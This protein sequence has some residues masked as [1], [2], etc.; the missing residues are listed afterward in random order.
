MKKILA[1]VLLPLLLAGMFACTD[2]QGDG[3]YTLIWE[4]S[5]VPQDSSFRNPVW[6]PDLSYPSVFKAAVSYYAIGS[7][8]EWS[9][10]LNLKAP[11]LSSTDLMS[12]DRRGEALAEEPDWSVNSI[13]A[14][15]AG[16]AKT[17]GT[18]YL[19]YQLGND[20]IGMGSSKSPQGPFVDYGELITP[21]SMGLAECTKPFF[22]AFGS[23]AFVFFQ[24]GD[25][26]YGQEL[27]LN[28]TAIAE[29][30]GDKFR[31]TGPAIESMN[32]L[33]LNGYYYLFGAVEDGNASRITIAR[34]QE[35]TGPYLDQEGNGLMNGEGTVILQGDAGNGFV[36]VN[37]IGG[38]FEDA[39]NNLWLIHQAT[40]VDLPALS[41]GAP[42]HPLVLTRVELDENG[43]PAQVFEARKG[44]NYPKFAK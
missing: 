26:M 28:K 11:V 13:T 34:S 12:W 5:T 15:S 24:G 44:W 21:G 19:F 14:V 40:D 43:W 2:V 10:G 18:Y 17:K 35:I 8:N 38:V 7:D 31:V 30:K 1:I 23:K 6:E 20:G 22:Y 42:R 41:S 9:P 25:G 39:N 37:H 36:A 4:G 29:L 16:F 33:Q 27:T 32:L 3:M